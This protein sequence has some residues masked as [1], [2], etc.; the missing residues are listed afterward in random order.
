[1]GLHGHSLLLKSQFTSVS[2]ERLFWGDNTHPLLT[3]KGNPQ[4]TKEKIPSKTS[5]VNHWTYLQKHRWLKDN[6]I[7][8]KQTNKQTNKQPLVAENSWNR[9]LGVPWVNC[10]P[11]TRSA[12]LFSPAI[13]TV[14]ITGEGALIILVSFIYFVNL[15]SFACILCLMNLPNPSKWECF[16]WK[17][18][19][20]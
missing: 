3:Q 7:T 1:M 12:Y 20:K 18:I 17:E 9:I 13:V 19:C 14:Y 6:C 5:L 10:P 4:Q 8:Y 11:L 16:N 15:V 2:R